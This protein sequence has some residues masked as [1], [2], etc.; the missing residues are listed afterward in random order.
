MPKNPRN[1]KIQRKLHFHDKND[2][3]QTPVALYRKLDDIYHFDFDPCPVNP[4]FDGLSVEWGKMNFVNP[5]YSEISKWLE[6]GVEEK[7]KGRTSLFL[8]TAR[9][10]TKYW[11]NYIVQHAK[12]ISFF[13]RGICFQGFDKPLPIPLCLVL[14]D[15]EIIIEKEKKEKRELPLLSGTRDNK[16]TENNRTAKFILTTSERDTGDDHNSHGYCT[17]EHSTSTE[18]DEKHPES[19]SD[20]PALFS[21]S[22][23][24]FGKDYSE[25]LSKPGQTY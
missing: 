1:K 6:K 3:V 23:D 14:F 24:Q 15:G 17:C 16:E 22:I 18:S 12:Q 9:T 5:P 11:Y 20:L 13:E 4:N 7:K 19:E 21:V 25:I 2:L 10:N 8:I